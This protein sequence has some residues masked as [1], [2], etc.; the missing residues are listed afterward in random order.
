MKPLTYQRLKQLLR[1]NKRTGVFTWRV[2]AGARA[3]KGARA[4]GVCSAGYWILR[5][6]RTSY[7][8]SRLAWFYVN[9]SWPKADIDHKNGNRADDRY[10][11]LRDVSVSVNVQNQRRAR[12]DN[13]QKVLGVIKAR[14][15]GK[16][17]A[18]IGLPDG[19][20]KW[21][22]TFDNTTD[23]GL[24]YLKAKRQLHEGCTL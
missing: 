10:A 9:G 16:F 5:I 19:T 8:A 7:R 23:A 17:A 24:A 4:G 12:A 22:G 13:Q 18:R 14:T 6:D 1:Y 11:N 15:K 20:R 3:L 2:T 21:L